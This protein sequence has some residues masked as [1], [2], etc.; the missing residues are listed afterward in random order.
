MD[1]HVTQWSCPYVSV[2]SL[3]CTVEFHKESTHWA[4]PRVNF[5]QLYICWV[6]PFSTSHISGRIWPCSKDNYFQELAINISNNRMLR[7]MVEQ[8][9][10]M[11][12]D[13]IR[14]IIEHQSLKQLSQPTFRLYIQVYPK[15]MQKWKIIFYKNQCKYWLIFIFKFEVLKIVSWSFNGINLHK[16]QVLK[17]WV[18]CNIGNRI[19]NSWL[20]KCFHIHEIVERKQWHG[21]YLINLYSDMKKIH[22]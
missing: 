5:C 17:C 2:F 19:L 12:K 18:Q 6:L 11:T 13:T 22:W 9:A 16:K 10:L 20:L 14:H 21:T 7:C 4:F 15:T 1:T 8:N 3:P